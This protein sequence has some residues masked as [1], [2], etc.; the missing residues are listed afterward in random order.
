MNSISIRIMFFL[1]IMQ[2]KFQCFGAKFYLR[3]QGVI[4]FFIRKRSNRFFRHILPL[5][6]HVLTRHKPNRLRMFEDRVL[7]R[8]FGPLKESLAGGW[9]N[10][11]K[12]NFIMGTFCLSGIC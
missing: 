1:D 5:K 12:R 6:L 11:I 9:R 8:I 10:C 2:C 7:R 3:L 4:I